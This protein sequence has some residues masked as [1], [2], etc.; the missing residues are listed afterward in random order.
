MTLSYAVSCFSVRSLGI[1]WWD[2][3]PGNCPILEIRAKNTSVLMPLLMGPT[4]ALIKSCSKCSINRMNM[5]W[6]TP[7]RPIL[8]MTSYEGHVQTTF[9]WS[10]LPIK[11]T[12]K[13]NSE[14]RAIRNKPWK[15]L[16]SKEDPS[17]NTLDNALQHRCCTCPWLRCDAYWRER[18]Q[19]TLW[20][21]CFLLSMYEKLIIG[22]VRRVLASLPPSFQTAPVSTY[23]SLLTLQSC[24]RHK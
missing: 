5:R 17:K 7:R 21:A 22:V 15:K 4:E 1:T 19:N 23:P 13:E 14:I 3:K 11:A 6:F 10:S 2:C 24:K 8:P 16:D 9:A 20:L 18:S 12:A